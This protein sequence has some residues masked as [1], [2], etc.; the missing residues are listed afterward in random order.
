MV[1]C[2]LSEGNFDGNHSLL[3]DIAILKKA[4]W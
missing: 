1:L 4:F 2:N 3:N